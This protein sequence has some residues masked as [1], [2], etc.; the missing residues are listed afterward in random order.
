MSLF[1]KKLSDGLDKS[2]ALQQAKIEFIKKYSPDPYYWA[3]FVLSGNVSKINIETNQNVLP[4]IIEVIFI[5][6]ILSLS[7]YFSKRKTRV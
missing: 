4:H 3:A 5:L 2:E 7:V 1:Y 6:L